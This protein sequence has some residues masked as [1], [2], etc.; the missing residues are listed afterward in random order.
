MYKLNGYLNAVHNTDLNNIINEDK[1]LDSVKKIVIKI[2]DKD[3]LIKLNNII[4][5]L[6]VEDH[7]KIPIKKAKEG[8]ILIKIN[9]RKL[10]SYLDISMMNISKKEWFD[11]LFTVEFTI[12]KY[13]YVDPKSH[14]HIKGIMF[15]L[16]NIKLIIN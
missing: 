6:Q 1:K 12:K 14:T 16:K 5:N 8:G 15:I 11:K 2:L 10:F 9:T 3:E 13:S 7:C 4:K